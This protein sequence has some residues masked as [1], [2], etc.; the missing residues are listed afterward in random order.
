MK[1]DGLYKRYMY[2]GML[3]DA[4]KF[5]RKNWS[6]ERDALLHRAGLARYRPVRR[7]F[8]AAG[9]LLAGGVLGAIAALVFTPRSGPE[10]RDQVRRKTMGWFEKSEEDPTMHAAPSA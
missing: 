4:M 2:R 3:N 7:G 1:V 5:A 10:M 8:S 6:V 9:L